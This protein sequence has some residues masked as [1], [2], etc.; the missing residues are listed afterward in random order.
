MMSSCGITFKTWTYLQ[1]AMSVHIRSSWTTGRKCLQMPTTLYSSILRKSV[2]GFVTLQMQHIHGF[3]GNYIEDT[4]FDP[5]TFLSLHFSLNTSL[6]RDFTLTPFVWC[7]SGKPSHQASSLSSFHT[8]KF[9]WHC[10][11]SSPSP[12]YHV[13][14]YHFPQKS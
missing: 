11:I 2:W 10:Y 4:S 8:L 6:A 5:H 12:Q 14:F 1:K 3:R 9:L 7:F 13:K